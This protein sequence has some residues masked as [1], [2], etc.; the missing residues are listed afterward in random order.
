MEFVLSKALGDSSLYLV[1]QEQRIGIF[2][3]DTSLTESEESPKLSSLGVEV[4]SS[5]CDPMGILELRSLI[6]H[7]LTNKSQK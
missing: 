6:S 7:C 1:K 4:I 5:R 3:A 2:N